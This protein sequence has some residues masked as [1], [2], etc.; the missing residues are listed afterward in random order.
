[1]QYIS[2]ACNYVDKTHYK[3]RLRI[4]VK[5]V[6][7]NCLKYRN[8]PCPVQKDS[9][10]YSNKIVPNEGSKEK[11]EMFFSELPNA[12]EIVRT[13]VE[14]KK[15]ILPE[16]LIEL[17]HEDQSK[18]E[19]KL[20][21]ALGIVDLFDQERI[22][23]ILK[24]QSP[25]L[26]EEK[27]VL[28]NVLNDNS[29]AL[30]EEVEAIKRELR[31]SYFTS[32]VCRDEYFNYMRNE[33]NKSQEY[34]VAHFGMHRSNIDQFIQSNLATI[35]KDTAIQCV[36]LNICQ[37]QEVAKHLHDNALLKNIVYWKSDVLDTAARSFCEAFYYHL[38]MNRRANCHDF[39]GAFQFA[40]EHI[41]S[42]KFVIVDPGKEEA[43]K[44]VKKMEDKFGTFGYVAAGIPDFYQL[45]SKPT[46]TNQESTKRKKRKLGEEEMFSDNQ[47]MSDVESQ[48]ESSQS[49]DLIANE[50]E[51]ALVV[52]N[53]VLQ[54]A[55]RQ[56]DNIAQPMQTSIN[57]A[58]ST[59]TSRIETNA[60]SSS[61]SHIHQEFSRALPQ[62]ATTPRNNQESVQCTV[63]GRVHEQRSSSGIGSNNTST[64]IP[65][66]SKCDLKCDYEFQEYR[67]PNPKDANTSSQS[68]SSNHIQTYLSN[69]Q[70]SST[71]AAS[72]LHFIDGNQSTCKLKCI[73]K[74]ACGH[75]ITANCQFIEYCDTSN[76]SLQTIRDIRPR[77]SAKSIS[78]CNKC[79]KHFCTKDTKIPRDQTWTGFQS[80]FATHICANSAGNMHVVNNDKDCGGYKNLPD[81]NSSSKY[82]RCV[83]CDLLKTAEAVVKYM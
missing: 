63:E 61:K 12:K 65:K 24:K 64:D 6:E 59:R 23:R 38:C 56:S 16:E 62:S 27:Y 30:D 68:N 13:I 7:T 28:I 66:N 18:F 51:Q 80:C 78:I 20:L 25:P 74:F 44:E 50:D 46:N 14:K 49:S 55:V 82:K 60:T 57:R 77:D 35:L 67:S 22:M 42:R 70:E 3:N 17:Y 10:N 34:K 37:S 43:K 47:A 79:G 29:L 11:L 5:G 48:V 39:E 52:H 21:P 72:A 31:A 2:E 40:K 36:F 81:A 15:D 41:K 73:Y 8:D 1:M 54:P 32:T 76:R 33:L 4:E 26:P 83:D 9:S 53:S 19:N 58:N 69:Q 71:R 75:E 45:P